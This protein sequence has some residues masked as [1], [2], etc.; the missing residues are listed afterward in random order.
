MTD[1]INTLNTGSS[2]EITNYVKGKELSRR[3][4]DNFLNSIKNN[5]S[6]RSLKNVRG[7]WKIKAGFLMV[8]GF[9]AEEIVVLNHLYERSKT[10]E[11]KNNLHEDYGKIKYKITDY[12]RNKVKLINNSEKETI[13]TTMKI[14][15]QTLEDAIT[16]G[17]KVS[18]LFKKAYRKIQPFRVYSKEYYWY[19]G[20]YEEH[21]F[22]QEEDAV[23]ETTNAMKSYTIQSIKKVEILE[24]ENIDYNFTHAEKI[25]PLALNSFISWDEEPSNVI[26]LI[27]KNLI[28]NIHRAGIY[29]H[30]EKIN[31]SSLYKDYFLYRVPSI[32]TNYK[33]IIPTIMK[34]APEIMVYEPE[35]LMMAISEHSRKITESFYSSLT[36]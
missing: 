21:K 29:R 5:F 20:G 8:L 13:S 9:K 22:K 10:I 4:I 36:K 26:L 30:W 28:N 23:T 2:I 35:R 25:L 31:Q 33:D 6:L 19:L 16:R 12:Y 24:N 15:I 3:S 14:S 34:H 17:K 18:I 27:H 7:V 32:H 1:I 11:Y